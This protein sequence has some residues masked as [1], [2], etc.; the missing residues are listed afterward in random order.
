MKIAGG[1]AA[2]GATAAVLYTAQTAMPAGS[3]LA[4]DMTPLEKEYAQYV[5]Q[6]RKNY[7][8]QEEYDLRFQHFSKVHHEISQ[9]NMQGKS[10]TLAHN[11][12]SDWTDAE[13]KTLNG[14]IP[15]VRGTSGTVFEE[16]EESANGSKDWRNLKAVANVKNQGQCGSCWAFSTTGSIESNTEIAHGTFTSLSEQQL[17]DCSSWNNGC[18]GG[19]F[20][21]AFD[22]AKSNGLEGETDYPY[23]AA[24][25]TCNFQSGKVKNHSVSGY[26]DVTAY[27]PA[28]LRAAVAQGPTSIAIQANQAV[29]Q[30]FTSGVIA[31]DGSCGEQLDHAVLAVGFG[32]MGGKQYLL[33]KNSW[34][35][36]WGDH[37]FVRLEMSG[38]S[39]ACGCVD[40]PSHVHVK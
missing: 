14:F 27:S 31:N 12:L 35:G 4:R 25:G 38:Y 18:G 28:Q 26:A 7:L 6:Y 40:Q 17:V 33:V 21:F 20:D 13:K 8:S 16:T 15:R 39:G 9:H 11:H 19:N 5:A 24:N 1:I 32:T 30:H 22:Y 37:G 3:F 29:F 2:V 36:S 23:W 10:W 34:G